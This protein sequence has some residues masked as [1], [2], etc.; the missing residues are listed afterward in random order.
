MM[1]HGSA[2]GEYIMIKIKYTS[3]HIYAHSLKDYTADFICHGISIITKTF[4]SDA[5]PHVTKAIQQGCSVVFIFWPL[6]TLNTLY[7]SV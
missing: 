4:I 6:Y 5:G 3:T 2:D 1:D 7:V